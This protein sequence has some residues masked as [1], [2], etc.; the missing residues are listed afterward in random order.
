V[1]NG[2][3]R[4]LKPTDL[5][6]LSVDINLIKAYEMVLLNRYTQ[7]KTQATEFIQ[8]VNSTYRLDE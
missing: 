8:H 7:V 5:V 4:N 2:S 3:M 6:Q 1:V